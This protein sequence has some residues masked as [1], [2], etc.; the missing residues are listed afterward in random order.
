VV[1]LITLLAAL[2]GV[3]GWWFAVG[4][5]TRAPS[6][7]AMSLQEAKDHLRDEGLHARVGDPVYSDSIEK[8]L[9]AVQDPKAG[10]RIDKGATITVQVSRGP[11]EFD[12]PDVHG[13][14]VGAATADLR[15][16][17]LKAGKTKLIYSDT[18]DEGLVIRTDPPRGTTLHVGSAVT[19]IVS[20]GLEPIPVPDVSNED[21]HKAT[22]ELTKAG[23]GVGTTTEAFSDTVPKD[24]VIST[25]PPGGSNAQPGATVNLVV[26]KG[27]QLFQVP[28]IT[29]DNINDAIREING[30]GFKAVP[31]QIFPGGPGN[32]VRYTPSGMQRKGTSIEIDYF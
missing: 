10:V 12:V 18:V 23:F 32:V 5:Y 1:A 14:T 27:P 31:S 2:G 13:E 25:D 20:K 26:S 6:L 21:V 11:S 19:L 29:G 7:I 22:E 28:D 15:A 9:V 24:K 4:G 3:A 16:V 17:S 8:G 30:A